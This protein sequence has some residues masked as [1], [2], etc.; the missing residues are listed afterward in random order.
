MTAEKTVVVAEFPT[1]AEAQVAL[2]RLQEES[3]PAH[4]TG[5]GANP[6]NF[7]LFGRMPFAPIQVHVFESQ[8]RQAKQLLSDLKGLRPRDGWEPEAENAVDGW[9]C[10]LCDTHVEDETANACPSCGEPRP[11]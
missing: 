9:I 10:Q 3:I 7:S 2:T 4:I 5:G 1:E 8:A 6:V 11:T